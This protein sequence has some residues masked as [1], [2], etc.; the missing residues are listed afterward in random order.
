[1]DNH[2]EQPSLPRQ[3]FMLRLRL[4]SW[5]VLVA[6]LMLV[7]RVFYLQ[8]YSSDYYSAR[9]ENNRISLLPNVPDR[10]IITD[11]NG[12]VLARNYVSL[13]VE[14]RPGQ[15]TDIAKT[16]E[17]LSS[18]I[19]VSQREQKRFR[20][21][22]REER[23]SETVPVRYHLSDNE[24][25]LLAANL[26][27]IPGI[28]IKARSFRQYPLGASVAHVIG[29][30]GRI[31]KLDVEDIA[32]RRLVA[33]YRGSRH[34]GRTGIE[35]F[36]EVDLHG[37]TGYQRVEVD[38]TGTVKRR[39]HNEPAIAGNRIELTLDSGLQQ[40]VEEAF[41]EHKGAMVALDPN[42]GDILALVSQ[43]S[44]DPNLF[45][46]G[47][48]VK[49]WRALSQ[50]PDKPL[51]NRAISG[52]YPP[53]STFKPFMAL[54]ALE[55]GV[56]TPEQSIV[57]PG[58][59]KLGNNTFRDSKAGGH[60]V[61]DMHKSIVESCD[62]Y[63]YRLAHEMGIDA[64]AKFMGGIGFGQRTGVD[65]HNEVRGVLPS[66]QWKHKRYA[67]S[68]RQKKWIGGETISVGIG[69]G[70]NSYTLIQL[71]QAVAALANDGVMH[72]PHLLK[73]IIDSQDSE[74]KVPEK[75]P[76][77][78]F[79]WQQEHIDLI[80]DAMVDVNIRGTGKIPFANTPYSAAGKTGTV[81]K[82]SL[83]GAIYDASRIKEEL[84]DHALFVAFAPADEPKIALAVIVENGGFGA[85]TAAPIARIA[86]DY[87]LLGKEPGVRKSTKIN[88]S[89]G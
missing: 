81:Q 53:G 11:R 13:S 44:F 75:P 18:L 73:R 7:A 34:I 39:L 5:V 47:I 3:K 32:R 86:L 36:Y 80:K 52:T 59:F 10:G 30:I 19:S 89:E 50:S 38:A 14:V 78:R 66:R 82:Y 45:V 41:G 67:A 23:Y 6:F 87:Y 20:R 60:G 26:Y 63:Y 74:T 43:P 77:L 58:Y 65:L 72:R 21:L 42:N 35:R 16:I 29:Y 57:D 46:E 56:R 9:A 88:R 76:P 69:Q 22:L 68:A 48:S 64:I 40:V 79:G 2:F 85:S 15:I 8:Y 4:I 33:N 70:Y 24:A 55:T 25:A 51:L 12:V 1:V 49:D 84:R 71:A 27:R 31:N 28:E 62:T 61:V 54:A 37:K 83:K 17:Q